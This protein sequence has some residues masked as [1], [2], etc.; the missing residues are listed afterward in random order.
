VLG[1]EL[2]HRF[3]GFLQPIDAEQPSIQQAAAEYMSPII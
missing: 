3:S 2:A 1:I